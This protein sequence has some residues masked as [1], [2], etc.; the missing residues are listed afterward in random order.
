MIKYENFIMK[1]YINAIWFPFPDENQ[2][3]EVYR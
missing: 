2:I 1:I 3:D